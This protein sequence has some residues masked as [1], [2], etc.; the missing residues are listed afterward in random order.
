MFTVEPLNSLH[1][2]VYTL[3]E[4]RLVQALSFL[5]TISHPERFVWRAEKFELVEAGA[6]S[7]PVLV[8]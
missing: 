3:L 5:E 6:S 1:L 7:K 2:T 4:T 8:H